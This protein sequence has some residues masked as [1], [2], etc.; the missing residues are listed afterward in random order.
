[1]DTLN[2][3]TSDAQLNDFFANTNMSAQQL[4]AESGY[5]AADIQARLDAAQGD[6]G[7][8]SAY[9]PESYFFFAKGGNVPSGLA[10]LPQ[11][12]IY[13]SKEPR[14]L[15]GASNGQADEIKTTID[16]HTPAA[17]SHGEFVIPADV[18]GAL[19]GG[20]SDAGAKT[21]YSMMDRVRQQATGSKQQMKAVNHGRVLPA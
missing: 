13:N 15:K 9:N 6:S 18:V 10:S 5:N 17:L 1:M 2:S 8:G 3:F 12:T 7:W 19:G 16:G 14:Y 20:N 4:A 21:L 11:D